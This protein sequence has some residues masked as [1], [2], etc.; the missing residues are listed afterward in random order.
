LKYYLHTIFDRG[1]GFLSFFSFFLRG[2]GSAASY[3]HGP[4]IRTHIYSIIYLV[5][6]ASYKH[7]TWVVG[8]RCFV[9]GQPIDLWV[10]QYNNNSNKGEGH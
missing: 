10:G 6:A 4:R 2:G 3:P 9:W 1:G 7:V 8:S 5:V